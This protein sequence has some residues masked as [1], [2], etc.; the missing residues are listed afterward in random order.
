M[1]QTLFLALLLAAIFAFLPA[2]VPRSLQ[3]ALRR[4][5]ALLWLAPF[6]LTAVFFAASVLASAVSV[7]QMFVVLAYTCA[8]VLCRYT[9]GQTLGGLA[10]FLTILLLWL[11]I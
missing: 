2:P 10:D 11:P 3:R 4:R 9:L 8:P 1:A 7:G 5:P 6:L